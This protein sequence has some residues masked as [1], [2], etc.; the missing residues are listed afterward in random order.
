MWTKNSL[1]A[2]PQ[3][4]LSSE[5]EI[6]PCPQPVAMGDPGNGSSY[7]SVL[8]IDMLFRVMSIGVYV[9]GEARSLETNL[10][11]SFY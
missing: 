2:L 3:Q 11:G 1:W 6:R 9:R 8:H 4:Q 10:Q 5:A 7:S